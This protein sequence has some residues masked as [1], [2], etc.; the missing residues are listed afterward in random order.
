[1]G[2]DEVG[3]PWASACASHCQ[4]SPPQV[5]GSPISDRR[6]ATYQ[7]H[8]PHGHP[9]TSVWLEIGGSVRPAG[10]A[11]PATPSTTAP[12]AAAMSTTAST[13]TTTSVPAATRSGDADPSL[14]GG[15]SAHE[16]QRGSHH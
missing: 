4:A 9:V 10:S 14:T 2:R 1:S 6:R 16:A 15:S 13:T 8:C 7:V 12:A 3:L 5:T 11:I